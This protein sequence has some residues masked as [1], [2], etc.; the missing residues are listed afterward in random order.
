MEWQ[1]AGAALVAEPIMAHAGRAGAG[2]DAPVWQ[3][4]GCSTAAMAAQWDALAC[5]IGQV[6][7][8]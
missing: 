4:M 6:E 7:T 2:A 8:C 3:G 1:L 5:I